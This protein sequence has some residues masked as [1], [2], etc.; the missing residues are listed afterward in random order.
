MLCRIAILPIAL[1][2]AVTFG[3]AGHLFGQAPEEAAATERP[4]PL[5]R[6]PQTPEQYLDAV[7]LMNRLTRP[8]LA[9]RYL[10]ELMAL[11]PDDTTLLALR[12]RHGTAIFLQLSQMRELQPTSRQLLER[13]VEASQRQLRDP[14]Y[15]NGLIAALAGSPRAR[16]QAISALRHLGADAAPPLIRLLASDDPDVDH[17]LIAFALVG[18]GQPVVPPLLGALNGP[19]LLRSRVVR[20]LGYLG[21]RSEV[22]PHLWYP[23]YGPDVSEVVQQPA[24]EAIARILYGE[25]GREAVVPASGVAD[26]IRD[27][28][29]QSLRQPDPIEPADDGRVGLWTW[30]PEQGTV[31]EERVTPH[32]YRLHIARRLAQQ[33][34]NL[35]PD[36]ADARATFLA[37]ALADDVHHS[38]DPLAIPTGEGTAHD[39]ATAAG[40]EIVERALDLALSE[41]NMP[42]AFGAVHVLSEIGD[43]GLV[44]SLAATRPPLVRALDAPDERVQFAA[45]AAILQLDPQAPFRGSSRVVDVLARALQG[46]SQPYAV[47]IDPNT[48]RA[49][50]LATWVGQQGFD[51]DIAGTARRGFELAVARPTELIVLHLNTLR[52]ELSQTITNLRADSRTATVP[53][54]VYGPRG[55]DGRFGRLIAD[56]Q[57]AMYLDEAGSAADLSI[58]LR[59]FVSRTRAEHHRQVRATHA[60]AAAYWLSRIALGETG[61]L[62][63]LRP[64]E[65]ALAAAVNEPDLADH[66]LI[67]LG[68]V[69]TASAQ[70]RLADAA[71]APGYD[72]AVRISAIVQLAQHQERFGWLL[73]PATRD[74][75]RGAR[76]NDPDP[77]V[78]AALSTVV[79][80]P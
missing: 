37:L 45:A 38:D 16:D 6:E 27:A 44:H 5:A 33:A 3:D 10:D 72:T 47:I 13:V 61:A 14:A 41:R 17:G 69:A 64:A 54:A 53:I 67:A 73:K 65:P 71:L 26:R 56:H 57:P 25:A 34:L 1:V 80:A 30:D 39:L 15:V 51:V 46:R 49:A 28:A 36:D 24:R 78:R 60:A 31:V 4:S 75:L 29:L 35:R 21:S 52:P 74:A 43:G 22:L 19:D 50:T 77:D 55:L 12:D 62:L 40:P 11:E 2:S 59:P 66:V 23:A 42:A 20:V 18:L 79:A 32:A 9:R 58:A 76:D 48:D 70:Q 68:A 8:E 63:D 7:L